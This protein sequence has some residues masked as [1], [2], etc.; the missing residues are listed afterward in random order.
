MKLYT[1][2]NILLRI[3]FL[4]TGASIYMFEIKPLANRNIVLT[5]KDLSKY[6]SPE[7][8]YFGAT[9]GPV[10]GRLKDGKFVLDGNEFK[11]QQNEKVTNTLHG[12]FT[13]FAFQEFSVVVES[14]TQLV[15]EYTSDE[16]AGGFPGLLTLRVIYTLLE[17][18]LE[19]NYFA[20]CTQDTLI[21]ITNHSYFNLDGSESVLEHELILNAPAVY[22]LD[23]KQI[24]FRPLKL[25]G[26]SPLTLKK[27]KKIRDV[28]LHPEVNKLPT[29]GLD[30]LYVVPD[31]R[32]VL[33]N[34]DLRL[35]IDATYEGYQIYSTNFPPDVTLVD[36]SRVNLYR[37]LAL[38][39][40]DIVSSDSYEYENLVLRNG[41]TYE[42]TIKYEIELR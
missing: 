16:N 3:T 19:V 33:E 30:H 9:V 15:F 27:G 5:T 17:N 11:T 13:S 12:G 24:N 18:G 42:K 10:A 22:E 38:E 8:A 20:S 4:T 7:N 6:K 40:V 39:P 25:K 32:L 36:D 26:S 34:S 1:L 31:G 2:E 35:T 37:G 23:D 41:E 29:M 21:N 28:V 14:S